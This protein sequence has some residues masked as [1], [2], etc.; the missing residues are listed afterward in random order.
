[1][2]LLSPVRFAVAGVQLLAYL[3]DAGCEDLRIRLTDSDV[4]LPD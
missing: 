3:G 2:G 1:M 4:A